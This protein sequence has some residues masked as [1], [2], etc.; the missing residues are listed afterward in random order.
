MVSSLQ[1]PAAGPARRRRIVTRTLVLSALAALLVGASAAPAAAAA[2]VNM[3]VVASGVAKVTLTGPDGKTDT[4]EVRGG[5]TTVEP[6]IG[7]GSTTI[8]LEVGGQTYN[9]VVD[10]PTSGQI[11]VVFNPTANPQFAVYAL[12]VEEVTVT[13]ERVEMNLQKVP[14]AVTA[15]TARDLQNQ[16][17]LN[18]QQISNQTPNLFLEKNTGT[19]SGSRAAIRGIGEDESFFTSDTPVGIYVDDVYIPRQTGAMF[20]LFELDRVE[21]LRGPQGTLYGRNTSAGAIKLVTRQPGN[22]LMANIEGIFGSYKQNDFIGAITVPMAGG[23]SSVQLAGMRRNHEGFDTNLVN[24]AKV[25]NQDVAGTR[26]SWRVVPNQTI[27]ILFTGDYLRERSTPGYAHGMVPQGPLYV[28]GVGMSRLDLNQQVGGLTDLRTLKSDLANPLNDIDEGGLS[29]TASYITG[30]YMFKSVTAYRKLDNLLELDAGGQQGNNTFAPG[31]ALAARP[32]F[33]L[34]QDQHQ[35]QWS[36]ELQLSGSVSPKVRFIA[37]YFYFHEQN[38][39][40]T[41]NLIFR[42]TRGTNYTD[43]ALKTDSNAAFGNLT[44]QPTSA[45]TITVGARYTR[46]GKDYAHQLMTPAGTPALGCF[47]P[48]NEFLGSNTCPGAAP[49]GSSLKPINRYLTPTFAGFTPRFAVDYAITPDQIV[50]GSVSRGFKSG[51]FDGRNTTASAIPYLQPI[52]EETLWT[53]EGGLKTDWLDN[54]LRLNFAAFI[55]SWDNLQGSGTDQQ[56]NFRRFSVGDVRTKGA[57]VEMRA[58]PLKGLEL[59]GSLSF[60][61]TEYTRVAFNQA[62]DCAPYGTPTQPL[63]LKYSP[64]ESYSF[65]AVYTLPQT[66]LG[67]SWTAVGNVAGKSHFFQNFCNADAGST[68]P[69]NLGNT[70]LAYDGMHGRIRVTGMV[71]NLWNEQYITG[72][73]T[74]APPLRF[75]SVYLNPPRR[76]SVSVRFSFR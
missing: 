1:Y 70:S 54:R 60:L 31:T 15:I 29:A 25:N 72:S 35:K 20:D 53:Y 16:S 7:A 36:E 32:I 4:F 66:M 33:W 38:N 26:A 5:A 63:E 50:Y 68:Y 10:M 48:N 64:H 18:V 44:L 75:E 69:Y 12:A 28:G 22:Q 40:I 11:Q 45:L 30:N 3:I 57:E 71:E 27:N 47:G 55:N 59:T 34:Y 8:V 51:A 52:S 39:Q 2:K 62:V 14:V 23:K 13:A 41:E 46:D 24:G 17:L 58:V 49:A 19:S 43:V 37:G 73:F 67:G 56:G 76:A 74:F 9:G 42:T 65:G 61:R 21:V 6:G